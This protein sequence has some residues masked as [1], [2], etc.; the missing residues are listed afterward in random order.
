MR[1]TQ[2]LELTPKAVAQIEQMLGVLGRVVEHSLRERAHGPVGALMLLVE[3]HAEEPLEERGKTE[4]ANP[5]QLG[6]HPRVEDVRR[7]PAVVLMQ[8]PQ[9]VIGVVQHDLDLPRFEQRAKSFGNA[10]GERIEDR[11]RLAR[12][13]L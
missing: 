11:A 6:C 8:E 13:E 2:P 4:R 10:D 1:S 12:G 9:I 7:V 5:E 3:L